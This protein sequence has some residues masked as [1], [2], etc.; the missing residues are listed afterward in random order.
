MRWESRWVQRSDKNITVTE[1]TSMNMEL[2]F[3]TNVSIKS[4]N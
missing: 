4:Q 2:A 1:Y 3:K